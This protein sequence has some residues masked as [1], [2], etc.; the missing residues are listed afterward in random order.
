MWAGA[1]V[2]VLLTERLSLRV[3]VLSS[4]FVLGAA[5]VNLANMSTLTHA[6][7]NTLLRQTLPDHFI[8]GNPGSN[9]N[10]Q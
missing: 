9:G 1:H 2:L 6:Y 7:P 5:I 3:N 8:H 4:I 10:I